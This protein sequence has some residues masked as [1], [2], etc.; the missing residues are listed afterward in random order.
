[1]MDMKI[2]QNSTKHGNSLTED[3]QT[4]IVQKF[5]DDETGNLCKTNSCLLMIGQK[6]YDKLHAKQDKKWSWWS[7]PVSTTAQIAAARVT[8]RC[9][10]MTPVSAAW[11]LNGERSTTLHRQLMEVCWRS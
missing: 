2:I 6:L 11:L 3:F 10:Q 4:T 7:V 9:L 1:M 8:E 5:S